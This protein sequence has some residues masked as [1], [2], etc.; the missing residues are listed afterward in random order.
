MVSIE[1]QPSGKNVT[2]FYL[3]ADKPEDGGSEFF[4]LFRKLITS[5]PNQFQQ[6]HHGTEGVDRLHNIAAFFL[7]HAKFGGE[8]GGGSR[9]VEWILQ[10][11]SFHCREKMRMF[12]EDEAKD[13]RKE[14]RTWDKPGIRCALV[15]VFTANPRK[16]L[17]RK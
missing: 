13:R 7:R 14:C 9:G 4:I 8:T 11:S 16:S 10:I 2:Y 1:R 3:F 17:L 12:T 15:S 6:F 5:F